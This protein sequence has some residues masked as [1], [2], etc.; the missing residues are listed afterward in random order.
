MKILMLAPEPFLE[1]RGTPLSVYQRLRAL[2]ALG[3]HVDLVTYHVGKA[4]TLPNLRIYRI[5]AIPFVKEVPIGPSAIKP[6]L[7][8]LLFFT[9]LLLLLRRRYNVIHSHEEAAFLAVFL[10]FIF[11]TRHIYDMHS[12][13][14]RQLTNFGFGNWRAL[15]WAFEWLERLVISTC[16]A[17]I[18][19][20]TD[21]EALVRKIDPKATVITIENLPV[22]SSD[23]HGHAD[24][25]CQLRQQL[26]LEDKRPIVY[27]GTFEV[28]QGLD[29][30]L[31][32]ARIVID[33]NPQAYFLVVGGKA[34]QVEHWQAEACK[35]GLF[36]HMRFVGTVPV[37]ESVTYLDLAEILVSPRVGGT[38][39]P[40][41]IYSY[42]HA[43]KPIVATR[44]ISH[45]TVLNDEVACLVE[46][47]PV[48]VASGILALLEDDQLRTRLSTAAQLHAETNYSYA[49]Y[50]EK[51]RL[52]YQTLLRPAYT[53]SSANGA[54]D[55][56]AVDSHAIA[57]D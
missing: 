55:A 52:I 46:P 19:I 57:Q 48:A 18:A 42:L 13:L 28:Y 44:L 23:V 31:H 4:V 17:V 53:E 9:A 39:V 35:L 15:V 5:P 26:A 34:H 6:V 21:L 33:A 25:V 38:S 40:L 11:R 1:A 56:I 10:G 22:T 3:H 49:A 41:K 43:G 32:S 36:T 12:S 37:E 7:D 2:S 51:V 16:D 54:A 14:P 47:T 8:I 30:L 50:K 24:S 45:T 29:L 20:G 27:A